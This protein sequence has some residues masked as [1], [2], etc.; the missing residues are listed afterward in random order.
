MSNSLFI[1]FEFNRPD[2]TYDRVVRTIKS[3]GDAWVEVHFAHWNVTTALTA[4]QVCERLKPALDPADELIVIDVTNRQVAWINLGEGA[5]NR[6][7]EQGF[8]G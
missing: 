3:L 7:R 5:S 4:D 1:S 2:R 8:R 6:L